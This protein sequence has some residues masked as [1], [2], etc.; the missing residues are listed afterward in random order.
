MVPGGGCRGRHGHGVTRS[1]QEEVHPGEQV[2]RAPMVPAGLLAYGELAVCG[3]GE[4][5]GAMVVSLK[6]RKQDG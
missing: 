2:M 1:T 6:Q 3:A 4:V 5:L